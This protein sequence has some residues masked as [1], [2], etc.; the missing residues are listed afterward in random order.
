M[1][2]FPEP[3]DADVGPNYII[4]LN[5]L[6]TGLQAVVTGNLRNGVCRSDGSNNVVATI[7]LVR[8]QRG[9]IKHDVLF[10]THGRS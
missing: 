3:L 8:Q 5:F 1:Q 4:Y 2:I 10:Q 7:R 6:I 9:H